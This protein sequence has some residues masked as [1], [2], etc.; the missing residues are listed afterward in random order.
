MLPLA[1]TLGSE[2]IC[3]MLKIIKKVIRVV[4]DDVK[5]N[6]P[7]GNFIE[8]N[9]SVYRFFYLHVNLNNKQ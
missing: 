9:S 8:L 4:V 1:M 2:I 6:C 3:A 5:L 7:R